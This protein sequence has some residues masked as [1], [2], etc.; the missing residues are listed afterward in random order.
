MSEDA[1]SSGI[2]KKI[3]TFLK[4]VEEPP[5]AKGSSEFWDWL[6]RLLAKQMGADIALLFRYMESTREWSFLAASGMPT[7][8]GKNP[9][10][11]AWQSLPTII[12]QEGPELFSEDISKDRLFIGQMIRGTATRTFAGTTLQTE[13][14]RLGSLSIG[15]NAPNA[16]TPEDR[17]FFFNLS[18][19]LFPFLIQGVTAP[20]NEPL[21]QVAVETTPLV[22]GKTP[23]TGVHAA[24]V[25]TP[26]GAVGPAV[27]A[28]PAAEPLLPGVTLPDVVTPSLPAGLEPEN[29]VPTE[30]VTTPAAQTQTAG[31]ITPVVV[32]TPSLGSPAPVDSSP[33][34]AG[35]HGKKKETPTLA[36]PAPIKDRKRVDKEERSLADEAKLKLLEALNSALSSV[37]LGEDFSKEILRKIVLILEADSGYLL[38]WDKES[39]RLFPVA[40]EGVLREIVKRIE[41]S[42]FKADPVWGKVIDRNQSVLLPFETWKSPLKRRICGEERYK[43]QIT[44]SVPFS[45]GTWGLL[46]LFHKTQVFSQNRLTLLEFAGQR[47]GLAFD[48]VTEW[49]AVQSKLKLLA[50]AQ[51]FSMDIT[52][53]VS[54]V[55]SSLLNGLKNAIHASNSYLLLLDEK[56]GVLYGAAASTHASD[57]IFEVEIRMEE[58]TI[59]PL[60]VKG[61]CPLV[62]ENTLSDTRIGKKWVDHFRSRSVLSMPLIAKDRVIGVL[63]FDETAYIRHFTE[64]EIRTVASLSHPAAQSIE[65]ATQYQEA[66][67]LRERQEHLSSAILRTHEQERHDL[68]NALEHQTWEIL[69]KAKKEIKGA[70]EALPPLL[71]EDS[72]TRK[73]LAEASGLLE[74]A[75]EGLRML[76]SDL[77]PNLL[78]KQGLIA[79]ISGYTESF[80]KSTGVSVQWTPP[81]SLKRVSPELELLLYRIVQEALNNVSRHADTKSVIVS[82]EKKDIYLYLAIT[83]AGR[84]FDA[85]RYFSAPQNKRKGTGILGMKGRVEQVG[86]IFF[87]ESELERGTR[88][89]IRVPVMKKGIS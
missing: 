57:T 14:R 49:D 44:V 42:G 41:K 4:T 35:G 58:E 46:S 51:N 20:A 26:A 50:L 3:Q 36:P 64:E 47:I 38:K 16:L 39:Q 81:T 69:E 40:S 82:I 37:F 27:V 70:K 23:A 72:G 74:K 34:E 32:T 18:K 63:L 6:L 80:F 87:I 53:G 78:E 12:A 67:R 7:D 76:S 9:L 25:T 13:G 79:A 71:P 1:L 75:V 8:F 89:S 77:R 33:G 10:P 17:A 24:R 29:G 55:F 62:I 56:R 11:R 65:T 59:A 60:T 68:A 61:R 54:V 15:F 2:P 45:N 84:G 31:V 19:S 88:V 28:P 5:F 85:K 21:P 22:A 30:V 52:K 83:D 86:G 73:H 48:A 66:V 43:S